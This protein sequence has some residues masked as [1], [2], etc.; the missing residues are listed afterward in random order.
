MQFDTH[1]LVSADNPMHL[2]WDFE[3]IDLQSLVVSPFVF[4]DV[5]HLHHGLDSGGA[6]ALTG[7]ASATDGVVAY[8]GGGCLKP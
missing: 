6:E 7:M 8:A 2:D 4:I 1:T 5:V 3:E